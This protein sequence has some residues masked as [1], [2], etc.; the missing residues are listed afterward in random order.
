M[1]SYVGGG[2][3]DAV[4]SRWFGDVSEPVCPAGDR[5]G[6]GSL[7]AGT[8]MGS[9]GTGTDCSG[10]RFFQAVSENCVRMCRGPAIGQ[11]LFQVR[12]VCVQAEEKVADVGPGFDP[13][14]F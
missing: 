10:S 9:A 7:A 14:A 3:L 1:G 11:H 12:I 6:R 13:M 2:A 5:F 8:A 4:L